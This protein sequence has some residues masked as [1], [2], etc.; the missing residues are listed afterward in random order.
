MGYIKENKVTS[1]IMFQGKV[2][3][4][5]RDSVKLENGVNTFREVVVHNGGACIVAVVD[6]CVLMVRQWRYAVERAMLELPAGKLEV[7]EDPKTCAV[8]ELEE[9]TGFVPISIESLGGVFVSPGYCTECIHMYFTDDVKETSQ[10]LDDNEFL[11]VE[12]IPLK[13]AFDMVMSGELCDAK[14]QIGVMRA[15]YKLNK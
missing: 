4:A 5:L 13:E 7:G 11:S 1:E 9:E 2:Y 14:T 12:H 6:G 10:N 3:T 8:R 15:Y